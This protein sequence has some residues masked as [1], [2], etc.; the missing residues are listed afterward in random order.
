MNNVISVSV[1]G[2]A[3]SGKTSCLVSMLDHIKKDFFDNI[4]LQFTI[5][6]H[7]SKLL[8]DQ[9]AKLVASLEKGAME[10]ANGIKPTQE[11]TR[12]NLKLG[13][14]GTE[15]PLPMTVEFIDYPGGWLTNGNSN[16]LA[17]VK[18]FVAKSEVLIIPIDA[19]YLMEMKD[20]PQSDIILNILKEIYVD[21]NKPRLV[22]L[23]PVKCEK[24]YGSGDSN[25]NKAYHTLLMKIQEKYEHVISFLSG[26]TIKKNIS[27]VIIPMQT[28]G[29]CKLMYFSE[30]DKGIKT[31]VFVVTQ[32]GVYAPKNTD[33]PFLYLISFILKSQYE[34]KNIG[35]G[36]LGR[37]LLKSHNYLKTTSE[38]LSLLCLNNGGIRVIQN[39][40]IT[41]F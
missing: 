6:S 20:D 36:G 22:I 18:E 27:I 11:I 16:N 3:G 15:A 35:L 21:L 28:L 23:T 19:A 17:H 37:R 31:P 30:N 2:V 24:Y 32:R 39:S 26:K 33:Q 5:D 1:L 13:K 8:I 34:S 41:T 14:K 4:N 12:Y 40:R 7:F 38:E 10:A 29:S 9:R 25:L